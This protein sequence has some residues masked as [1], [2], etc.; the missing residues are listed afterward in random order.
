MIEISDDNY[1]K[2]RISLS[3][4]SGHNSFNAV[5]R[6]AA[7]LNVFQHALPVSSKP[8]TYLETKP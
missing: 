7:R 5:H 3:F 2:F 6:K 8:Q 1:P 4:A